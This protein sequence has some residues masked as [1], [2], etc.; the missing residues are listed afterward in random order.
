[1]AISSLCPPSPMGEVGRQAHVNECCV[2]SGSAPAEEPGA[3]TQSYKG[4][5][6]KPAQ[7]LSLREISFFFLILVRQ[8]ICPLPWTDLYFC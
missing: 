6:N 5:T 3:E 8:Q 2:Q 1:M 4:C 7:H